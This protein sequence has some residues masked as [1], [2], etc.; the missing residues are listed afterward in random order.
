MTTPTAL[1]PLGTAATIDR[2]LVHRTALEEVFL[3]GFR[4]L[5]DGRFAGSA[6]LPR[7]HRYYNDHTNHPA[8]HD[9]VAIFECVRQMLLCALHLH[10]DAPAGMKAITAACRMDLTDPLA[11]KLDKGYDLDLLGTVA[12]HK[13]REGV[14]VRVLHEVEVRLG[15]TV[16]GTIAV[17]T[18]QKDEQRYQDLRMAFRDTKPPM[19]DDLLASEPLSR[20]PPYLVGRQERDN[21][22][23][24]GPEVRD[25]TLTGRLR[26]PVSHPGMFDHPQDHVPGP[27]MMEAARQAGTLLAG[28]LFGQASSKT[29][30]VGLDAAYTRFAELD[31]DILI[32]ATAGSG[33]TEPIAVRFLQEGEPVAE[34]T[35]RM[36]NTVEYRPAS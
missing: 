30:L 29:V 23:L 28:E 6:R 14:T 35:I 21:V 33:A 20:V 4:S 36:A 1:E 7:A 10:H 8:V 18:A 17:D 15:S 24:L 5:P 26:V 32:T 27:V 25:G 9:P 12:M 22:L 31:S 11:L 19:S 34:M 16:L 2:K 3:T 13:E